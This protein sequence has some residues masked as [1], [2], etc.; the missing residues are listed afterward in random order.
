MYGAL[1]FYAREG[2]TM[3]PG[4][5]TNLRKTQEELKCKVTDF[6]VEHKDPDD[7]VTPADAA[8]AL[9]V[10]LRTLYNYRNKMD[11]YNN[12]T[13]GHDLDYS[14]KTVVDWLY[15]QLESKVIKWMSQDPRNRA[16]AAA[17]IL[18]KH[19]G[20][21]D[22]GT[23]ARSTNVFNGNTQVKIELPPEYKRLAQ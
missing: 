23:A 5:I 21:R 17:L 8:I 3:K 1:F 12:D 11:S 19:F 14:F 9:N 15:T 16:T 22:D 18:N 4:T 2:D 7:L 6:L 10:T 13:A 20:Y